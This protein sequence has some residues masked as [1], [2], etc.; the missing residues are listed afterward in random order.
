M[1]EWVTPVTDRTSGAARMTHI[2]MNRITGNL[3]FLY[4][5]CQRMG[6]TVAGDQY[7]KTEWTQDDIVTRTQWTEAYTCLLN[8][9]RAVGHT[10]SILFDYTTYYYTINRFEAFELV[11]FNILQTWDAIPRLNHWIGD[12]LYSGDD[13]NAGGR[14]E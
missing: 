6:I 1:A 7:S 10:G 4:E 13:F 9:Y 5:E 8:L 2:D 3:V 11:I 12:A 14:Y